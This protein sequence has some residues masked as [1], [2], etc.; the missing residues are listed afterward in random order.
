MASERKFIIENMKKLLLKEYIKKEV[1]RAGFGGVDIQR[2]PVGTRVNLVVERPGLVIGKKGEA[3]KDMTEKIEKEF[4]FD[5]PLVEVDEVHNPNL[6]A[7]IMAHKVAEALERGWHF[8]RV[9][10]STVQRIMDSGARGCQVVISG[11]LTGERHRSEKFTAGNIKYCGDTARIWMDIGYSIAKTKPGIMGVKV[12]IMNPDSKLPDDIKIL[13]P[14]TE[15]EKLEEQRKI[16]E[17][18]RRIEERRKIEEERRKRRKRGRVK[19]ESKVIKKLKKEIKDKGLEEE[20]DIEEIEETM[21]EVIEKAE[22]K[23][24]EDKHII[25]PRGGG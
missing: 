17:E 6:N 10:H 11:K 18:Q 5:N 2:T 12:K 13:T 22:V 25:K 1:E 4:K 9:G 21:T 14:K 19:K 8:R 20:I 23:E 7:Q 3:I 24:E 15:E 16:E